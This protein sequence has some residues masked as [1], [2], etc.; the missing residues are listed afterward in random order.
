M[1]TIEKIFPVSKTKKLIDDVYL[2]TINESTKLIYRLS[3]GAK[4]SYFQACHNIVEGKDLA[5]IFI[6][7]HQRKMGSKQTKTDSFINVCLMKETEEFDLFNYR[8]MVL[9]EDHLVSVKEGDYK[10]IIRLVDMEVSNKLLPFDSYA[11]KNPNSSA[12]ILEE[13][14]WSIRQYFCT[15]TMKQSPWFHKEE[16]INDNVFLLHYHERQSGALKKNT[17]LFNLLNFSSIKDIKEFEFLSEDYLLRHTEDTEGDN[18]CKVIRL[19]DFA[20]SKWFDLPA[21]IYFYKEKGKVICES[22]SGRGWLNER[23]EWSF[24]VL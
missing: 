4:S 19:S 21:K 1:K 12:V 2:V 7:E 22:D 20:S 15:K 18:K 14:F 23:M 8:V 16:E 10:R 5:H 6:L 3:D 9:G 13:H 11:Y 17:V 24:R